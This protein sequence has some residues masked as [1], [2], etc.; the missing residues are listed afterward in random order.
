MD[1]NH[2]KRIRECRSAR[3][4]SKSPR[5]SMLKVKMASRENAL[6]VNKDLE[7]YGPLV[8]ISDLEVELYGIT[9]T[10]SAFLTLFLYYKMVT[11]NMVVDKH[12]RSWRL[13][14]DTKMNLYAPS[15]MTTHSNWY[16]L[17]IDSVWCKYRFNFLP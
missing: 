10:E 4:N 11:E 1:E 8:S 9:M 15:F 2:R 6:V 5:S 16:Y 12:H 7:T 14:I 17:P 13:C 3:Q